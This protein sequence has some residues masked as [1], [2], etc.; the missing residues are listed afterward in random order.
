MLANGNSVLFEGVE[1]FDQ[2]LY[3]LKP[4]NL[5]KDTLSDYHNL[6][7]RFQEIIEFF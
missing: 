1:M 2:I 7:K 5:K 6:F 4:R 3:F